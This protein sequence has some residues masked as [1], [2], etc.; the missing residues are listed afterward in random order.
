MYITVSHSKRSCNYCCDRRVVFAKTVTSPECRDATVME[1]DCWL[2]PLT[3]SLESKGCLVFAIERRDFIPLTFQTF[4]YISSIRVPRI[5]HVTSILTLRLLMS[6][7]H[8]APSK[9]RNANVVYIWTY[10]W[11]RW[12]SLFLF[13]AQC[14][15][16]KSMQRGFLCHICV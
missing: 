12:N 9:A 5:I 15:N 2:S 13:S 10:V 16:T 8:G 14:F 3:F 4:P 1:S 11:Q 6:Y 7:I